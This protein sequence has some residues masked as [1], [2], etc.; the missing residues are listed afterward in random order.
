MNKLA[1][2]RAVKRVEVAGVI[3]KGLAK[4]LLG[5]WIAAAK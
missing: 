2:I 1:E 3:D 5:C 4:A